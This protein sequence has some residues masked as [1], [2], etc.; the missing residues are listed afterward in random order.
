MNQNISQNGG[1]PPSRMTLNVSNDSNEILNLNII[2]R[3]YVWG[4]C[5]KYSQCKY[6]HECS[7]EEMKTIIQFCHDFQNPTG[8]TRPNC[9]YLHTTS[10]EEEI[11]LTT[12]QMPKVLAERHLAINAAAKIMYSKNNAKDMFAKKHATPYMPPNAP[13]TN[14]RPLHPPPSQMEINGQFMPMINSAV[15]PS[16]PP[17]PPPPPPS[18][19]S[20]STYTGAPPPRAVPPVL[21][22][23][24]QPPQ[25][26]VDTSKPPPPLPGFI[27]VPNGVKRSA[28]EPEAGPSKTRKTDTVTAAPPC[29][30][31]VQWDARSSML[32]EEIQKLVTEEKSKALVIKKYK[33]ELEVLTNFL[34]SYNTLNL[35][36]ELEPEIEE[37]LPTSSSSS[38]STA[39]ILVN[40]LKKRSQPSSLTMDDESKL[41]LFL[42][43]W[44]PKESEFNFPPPKSGLAEPSRVESVPGP[45]TSFVTS[46]TQARLSAL[47][48]ASPSALAQATPSALAQATPSTPSVGAPPPAA[49]LVQAPPPPAPLVP[50]P[51]PPATLT[52]APPH[53]AA[54]TQ[55]PPPVLH[56]GWAPQFNFMP[57]INPSFPTFNSWGENSTPSFSEPTAQLAVPST[58]AG[59]AS[60]SQNMTYHHNRQSW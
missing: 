38:I 3:D 34:K 42:E 49:A 59:L 57:P 7:V 58:S 35:N 4:R 9:T 24:A 22:Q 10:K 52:Q 23:S 2:C 31:C 30:A 33:K 56:P 55:A 51:P 17:P 60:T 8:C 6:R 39:D 16:I 13:V 12:G 54:L 5:H 20:P 50:A 28:S 41:K 25:L 36:P 37:E 1:Q 15:P 44:R 21:V 48:Q 11:F 43:S 32:D 18:E 47:A 40:I 45:S 27:K 19:V 14:T 46:L 29:T 53:I 26:S